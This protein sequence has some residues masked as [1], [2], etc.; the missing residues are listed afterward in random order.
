MNLQTHI[1]HFELS[2]SQQRLLDRQIQKI[3][4][5]LPNFRE[6]SVSLTITMDKLPRGS[7]FQTAL[8]LT[9]PGRSIRVEE[10]ENTPAASVVRSFAELARRVKKVKSRMRREQLWQRRPAVTL[11]DESAA[12]NREIEQAIQDNLE[13]VENYVSREIYHQ[14]L[15]GRM[16]AG[17]IQ[18]HAVVDEVFLEVTVQ[19]HTKPTNITVENWIYS[20]AR[21]KLRDRIR[22]IEE[23]RDEPHIE[24][25]IRGPDRDEDFWEYYQPDEALRVEDVLRD[26]SVADPEQILARDEAI[27]HLN[28]EIARLPDEIRESFVL[29]AMEG[30]NSDEVAMITGKNR[31]QV[32]SDVEEA[33]TRLAARVS[34]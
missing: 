22:E 26:A 32:L 10:I 2:E 9:V 20:V 12:E 18:P 30:F 3:L 7:Q 31:E 33:R 29:F 21:E 17:L 25:E 19:A 5:I 4:R 13:K 15:T 11:V 34:P 24:E 27:Q 8:L 1:R 16:P 14:V 28:H 23:Q 6:D